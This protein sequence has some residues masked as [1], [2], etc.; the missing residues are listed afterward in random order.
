VTRLK[1]SLPTD[2]TAGKF[3]SS[4]VLAATKAATVFCNAF[5]TR[6]QTARDD[7]ASTIVP[8]LPDLDWNS[9]KFPKEIARPVYANLI[10]LMWGVDKVHLPSVAETDLALDA[11]VDA[12]S[13]PV[14]IDGTPRSVNLRGAVLGICIAVAVSFPSVE[15]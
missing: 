1:V 11:L 8:V 15:I 4:H 5:L 9:N 6:E 7:P 3:N 12:M 10:D 2:N 13:L 14:T